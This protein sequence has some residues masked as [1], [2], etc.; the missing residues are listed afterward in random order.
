LAGGVAHDF[1]NILLAISG[2]AD[3]AT[4]DLPPEHPSR[5]NLQ[6]ISASCTRARDLVRQ[7]LSFSRPGE[8]TRTAVSPRSVV[9]EAVQLLRSTVPATVELRTEFSPD[10]PA[11]LADA[12]QVHEVLVNLGMNAA[13]AIGHKPGCIVFGTDV[14]TIAEE[15]SSG[16]SP[17]LNPGKYVRLSVQD[18]GSGMDSVT[19]ERLFDPFFTSKP[20]GQG[21]G[22]G[23][24]VAHGIV[25]SHNGGIAVE[26][27]LERGTTFHVYF[28]ATE[29]PVAVGKAT[30]SPQAAQRDGVRVLYIDDE[31]PLVL[32]AKQFLKR[33]GYIV[34]GHTEAKQALEDFR[35]RPHDFDVVVTD[36]AMPQMSGF[37]LTREL[38]ALRSDVL[39]ILTSGYMKPEDEDQARQLGVHEVIIKPDTITRLQQVL[40][41]L[42]P[43]SATGNQPSST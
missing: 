15:D 6:Q 43:E 8:P 11:I 37:D 19:M 16:T 10:V 14:A 1:N 33:S 41:E 22:L 13:H 39:V 32:L 34:T 21:T 25:E 5:E 23:L 4:V 24:S 26:S 18:D 3:L 28:P 9:Q 35:K 42:F 17:A 27:Q 38:L 12:S 20:K 40:A 2:N 29:E 7:I 30:P 31:K 36:L